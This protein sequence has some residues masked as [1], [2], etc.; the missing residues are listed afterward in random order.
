MLCRQHLLQVAAF[1]ERDIGGAFDK[2]LELFIA[3]D[4][5][6]FSVHFDQGA[7]AAGHGNTHQAFSGHAAGLLAGLGDTLFTQPVD[8]RFHVAAGFGQRVLTV[9]H[10]RAGLVAQVFHQSGGDVGHGEGSI[11]KGFRPRGL[12]RAGVFRT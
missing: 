5:I 3:G 2:A 4:E 11:V 8:G 12:I 7:R 9:H 10:A 6:G 1:P